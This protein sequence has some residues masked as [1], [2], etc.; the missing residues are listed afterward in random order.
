MTTA[1]IAQTPMLT[2]HFRTVIKSIL[3]VERPRSD[4]S[5][6]GEMQVPNG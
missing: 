2:S 3:E 5:D 4:F 1:A 6:A